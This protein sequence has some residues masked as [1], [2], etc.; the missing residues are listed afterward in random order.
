MVLGG[1]GGLEGRSKGG[2]QAALGDPEDLEGLEDLKSLAD[3]EVLDDLG[4]GAYREY[5]RLRAAWAWGNLGTLGAE[6]RKTWR[7]WSAEGAS[8]ACY[9]P[10]A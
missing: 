3:L 4:L 6:V 2:L 5:G 7:A 10:P 8:R 1:L 9:S